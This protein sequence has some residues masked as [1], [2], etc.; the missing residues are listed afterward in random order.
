MPAS[1]RI[2]RAAAGDLSAVLDLHVLSWRTAYA[3]MVGD[4][5]LKNE[6]GPYFEKAWRDQL[7]APH[8]EYR[9]WVAR[10]NGQVIAFADTGPCR[11]KG[12]RPGDAELYT[13][14]VSPDALGQGIGRALL[15]HVADDLRAR[16]WR[17][18]TAWV[19][20]GNTRARRFYEACGWR[21]DG[22]TLT[23]K[24]GSATLHEVRYA[25]ALSVAKRV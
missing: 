11:D 9:L 25:L 5:F 18:V 4:E 6:I 13:I 22:G 10:R 3:G 21:W 2:E 7:A 23:E 20:E 24:F 8:E 19:L 16:G 1:V 14:H 17:H 12:V 15:S